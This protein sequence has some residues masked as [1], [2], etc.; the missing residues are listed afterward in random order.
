M[1]NYLNSKV[2][3][4]VALALL[5]LGEHYYLRNNASE[6]AKAKCAREP[7]DFFCKHQYSDCLRRNM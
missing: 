3:L 2:A 4:A 5:S 1:E 6:S 7:L